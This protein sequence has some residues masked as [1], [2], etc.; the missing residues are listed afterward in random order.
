MRAMRW[1]LSVLLLCVFA[2]MADDLDA[3]RRQVELSMVITGS[4]DIEED[5]SVSAH[6]IDNAGRVPE[7]VKALVAQVA[8]HWKFEPIRVDGKPV[9]ARADMYLRLIARQTGVP[10]QYRIEIAGA[11]FGKS[12][13]GAT[14]SSARMEPPR[15]PDTAWRLG[16]TGTVYVLVMVGRDGRVRDVA[17]E[18]VNLRVIAKEDKLERGRKALADAAMAA[19]RKWTFNPPTNGSDVDADHW[20]VRVP[21]T[22]LINGGPARY[23]RWEDAIPGPRQVPPWADQERDAATSAD[24]VADGGL[25]QLGQGFRLLTPLGES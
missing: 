11:T 19:A 16:A 22:F 10:D 4:A 1:T 23:G 2:A 3:V 12:E 14:V 17:A 21:V 18:Q 6:R 15:Y 20:I 8:P 13:P 5:G 25:F 7:N 9:K 24:A